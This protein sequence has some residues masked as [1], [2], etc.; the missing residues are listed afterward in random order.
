V[1]GAAIQIDGELVFS[2]SDGEFLARFQKNKTVKVRVSLR[3]FIS[4]DFYEVVSSPAEA[5]PVEEDKAVDLTI[6]LRHV[7][8]ATGLRLLAKE[9]PQEP[10]CRQC[11]F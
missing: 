9:Q 3:D 6:E 10:S 4:N 11:T 5:T 8:P 1:A 2:N 7:D